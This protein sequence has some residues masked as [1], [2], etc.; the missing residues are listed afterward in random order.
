M[1]FD[2]RSKIS[3]THLICLYFLGKN[4]VVSFEIIK[5]FSTKLPL[6]HH[7]YFKSRNIAGMQSKRVSF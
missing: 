6:V 3:I 2:E 7:P 1:F 4:F 5:L